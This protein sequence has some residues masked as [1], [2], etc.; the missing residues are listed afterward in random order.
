MVRIALAALAA[1]LLLVPSADA[2]LVYEAGPAKRH[3]IVAARNDGSHARVVA[4]GTAPQVSPTGHL[5]AFFKVRRDGD[6]L[7]VVDNRG[8]DR[9]L[10]ARS[11]WGP[12][13]AWSP[14]DRYL[15]ADPS[16]ELPNYG[17]RLIDVR[18]RT[19]RRVK[20][21][22]IY[23]GASFTPDGKA[24]T[25]NMG[26]FASA[27]VAGD[28]RQVDPATRKSRAIGEGDE[29]RWGTRGLAYNFYD[30]LLLRKHLD[31]RPETILDREAYPVDWS[32]DG[33][34][35]LAWEE[36][37]LARQAVIIDLSPRR[38]R[39][40]QEPIFPAA[41]SRDGRKVLGEMDGDVVERS[42]DGAIRVLARDATHPSWTK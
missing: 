12:G 13:V 11:F 27:R 32:A 1:A 39:R 30:E 20:A 40:V 29:P 22:G 16:G 10:L 37:R 31:E 7:Y 28:L 34:R 14:D 19:A 2:V 9:H 36:S 5:I 3:T 24:F 4:H 33:N 23:D 35:L 18:R 15:V 21:E 42:G 25:L 6:R 26:S 8:R 17:A 41:L 38:I